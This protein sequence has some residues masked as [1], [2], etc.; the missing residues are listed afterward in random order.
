MLV[1]KTHHL[2]A[3]KVLGMS[4]R[5]RELVGGKHPIPDVLSI[6]QRVAQTMFSFGNNDGSTMVIRDTHEIRQLVR[7]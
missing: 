3:D 2:L 7:L 1:P 6:R 5:L 4:A